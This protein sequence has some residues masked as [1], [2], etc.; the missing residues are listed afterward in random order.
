[1]K[2]KLLLIP[3]LALLLLGGCVSVPM[4]PSNLDS[5]A[6][7]FATVPDKSVIYIYRTSSAGGLIKM[8]VSVD[9]KEIGS[10]AYKVYFRVVVAPGNHTIL[11][12]ASYNATLALNTEAGKLYFVDQEPRMGILYAGAGLKQV[13]EEDGRSDVMDCKL[14]QSL[15]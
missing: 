2:N 9:G 5:D 13:S 14:A 3:L 12:V 15:P 8:P 10:T 7:T 6:K 11:A 1:M 4:A